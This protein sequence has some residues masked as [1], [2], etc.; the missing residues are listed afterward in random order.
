M[1]F[2]NQGNK[3]KIQ[4]EE[5]FTARLKSITIWPPEFSRMIPQKTNRSSHTA[6]QCFNDLGVLVTG[7]VPHGEM[8]SASIV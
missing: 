6:S 7:Y 5:S 3:A 1:S 8:T 4:A 2:Q